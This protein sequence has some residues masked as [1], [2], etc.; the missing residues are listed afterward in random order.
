MEDAES[1]DH[2]P[3]SEHRVEAWIHRIDGIYQGCEAELISN[4]FELRELQA[5][6]YSLGLTTRLTQSLTGLLRKD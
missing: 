5:Q 6:H 3:S 1:S 4:K 2:G